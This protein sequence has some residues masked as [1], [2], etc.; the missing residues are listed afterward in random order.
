MSNKLNKNQLYNSKILK[1]NEKDGYC[2]NILKALE[3][4]FKAELKNVLQ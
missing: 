1:T 2:L 3:Y 4:T